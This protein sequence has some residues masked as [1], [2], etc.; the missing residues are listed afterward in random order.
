MDQ[1]LTL[2]VFAVYVVIN[3]I[4]F[5][6]YAWDKHKAKTDKWRTKE[7]TLLLGALFGPWGAAIGMKVA[8][9]KTQKTKFKLV[10]VFLVLHIILI[11]Y[12]AMNWM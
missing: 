1:N 12:I 5:A 4:V 9:H 6:M 10:Y 8:H 11:A 7:S 3:A 2:V